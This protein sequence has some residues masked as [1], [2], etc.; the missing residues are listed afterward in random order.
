MPF[1]EF[2]DEIFEIDQ[3]LFDQ[4]DDLYWAPIELDEIE[5]EKTEWDDY[6]D[7]DSGL[8]IAV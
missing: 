2:D 7:I 3:I 8:Q 6:R 4:I 1:C 5:Y